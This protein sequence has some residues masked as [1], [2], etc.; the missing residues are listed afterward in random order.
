M[1]KKT[2]YLNVGTGEPIQ[3]TTVVDEIK[4]RLYREDV[5]ISLSNDHK[6]ILFADTTKMNDMGLTLESEIIDVIEQ[7]ILKLRKIN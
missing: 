3:L 7:L 4:R 5:K 2:G 1:K 6:S